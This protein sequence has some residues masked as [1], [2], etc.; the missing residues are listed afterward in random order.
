MATS[1]LT[2]PHKARITVHWSLFS[3]FVVC[4][5]W[6]ALIGTTKI[7]SSE[8]GTVLNVAGTPVLQAG[9]RLRGYESPT[10]IY[11]IRQSKNLMCVATVVRNAPLKAKLYCV[12]YV[13]VGHMRH[14]RV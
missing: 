7:M 2:V 4:L 6:R 13:T 8:T 12:I 14:V 9:K 11:I 10:D 3:S 5:A 1:F